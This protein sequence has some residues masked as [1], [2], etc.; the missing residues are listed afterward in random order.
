MFFF[1]LL[2]CRNS[3]AQYVLM[4]VE[5]DTAT[6]I[7]TEQVKFFNIPQGGKMRFQ[8][9]MLGA[10]YWLQSNF[11]TLLWDTNDGILTLISPHFPLVDTLRISF[12]V[13][14]EDSVS[15][16]QWGEA[17]LIC[18]TAH[19]KVHKQVLPAYSL[20]IQQEQQQQSCQQDT[21]V[22]SAT[23]M[24]GGYY[25]VQVSAMRNKQSMKEMAKQMHMQKDDVLLE[26][27]KG[28]FHCYFIGHFATKEIA[29]QKLKYYHTYA[30]DAFVVKAD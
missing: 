28:K 30:K 6:N 26:K 7:L 18:E 27:I 14:T 24:L 8:Q 1:V 11:S 23:E 13:K 15:I 9:R 4:Q 5:R 29:Q 12:S 16:Q 22:F 3:F 20:Y 21:I 2:C 17:A 10:N 25:Y 19:G